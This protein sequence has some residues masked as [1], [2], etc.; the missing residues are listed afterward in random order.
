MDV[1]ILAGGKGSRM[2]SIR[3]KPLVE[4]KNKPILAY[5]LDNFFR[6]EIVGK[7]ILS[8]GF[9]A[10]DIIEFIQQKYAQA[11]VEFSIEKE[12]LGTGGA[13]KL[14]LQKASSDY[15]LI[16]NCDDL[17]DLDL[18]QLSEIKENTICVANPRLPFGLVKD[19]N[20]Y[21]AFEEKPLLS[22]MWVSCGW[23][24]L[25][26]QQMLDI[27][28]DKSSLE[29]DVYP[30]IKLKLFKHKGFWQPVNTKKDITEFESRELPQIFQ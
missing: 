30:Q 13:I 28:P 6:Y 18:K 23:V 26:R 22:D 24:V 7:I 10:G 11:P 9:K 5:Q 1:I 19:N 8:L 17:T 29:Y 4:L 2:E 27:I 21:A 3:P 15:V 25:S 14:G 16:L 20:G 12:T